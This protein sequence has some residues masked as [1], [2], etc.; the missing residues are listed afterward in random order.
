MRVPP[1]DDVLLA[2]DWLDNY[3]SHD[4]DVQERLAVVAAYLRDMMRERRR[5]SFLAAAKRAGIPRARALA[6]AQE[7]GL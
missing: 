5:D 7:I 3:E 6:K 1:E 4:D 2:A